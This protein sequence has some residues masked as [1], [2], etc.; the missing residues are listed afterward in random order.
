MIGLDPMTENIAFESLLK[1]FFIDKTIVLCDLLNVL[2][3]EHDQIVPF[4]VNQS[5]KLKEIL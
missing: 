1:I 4:L 5:L 2:G 3:H